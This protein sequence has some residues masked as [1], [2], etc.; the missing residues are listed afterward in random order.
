MA[1][2]D[3]NLAERGLISYSD[4]RTSAVG[5]CSQLN[6]LELQTGDR[7]KIE[8]PF[9]KF[10]QREQKCLLDLGRGASKSAKIKDSPA[11]TDTESSARLG[12]V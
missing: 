4:A 10:M 8:C 1:S 3:S 11:S 5:E 6:L 9:C 7:L 2:C 12:V